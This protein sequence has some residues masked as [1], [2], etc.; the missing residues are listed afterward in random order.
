[1][2]Q[3]MQDYNSDGSAYSS[4]ELEY[5]EDLAR[6]FSSNLSKT[7]S[8]PLP[9]FKSNPARNSDTRYGGPE[10]S[11]DG[12]D[13]EYG[14]NRR[15]PPAAVFDPKGSDADPLL[16]SK[17]FSLSPAGAPDDDDY[18]GGDVLLRTSNLSASDSLWYRSYEFFVPPHLP[19]A[20][21][22]YHIDNLAIPACYLLVGVLQGLSGPLLNV[23]PLDIGATEAQQITISSLKSLPASFKLLFG[24]YSDGHTLF[25]YRRKSYMIIGWYMSALAMLLLGIHTP[26]GVWGDASQNQGG[27]ANVAQNLTIPFV[28]AMTL[29]FGTGG[30]ES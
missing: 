29:L 4:D 6:E 15:R 21:Q 26:R 23:L 28:S 20:V 7:V 10:D 17:S 18:E 5:D 12:D 14:I 11:D 16:T 22:L 30:N 8:H 13:G 1:M 27:D 19:R 3:G 24:F 2:L 25:G 9:S